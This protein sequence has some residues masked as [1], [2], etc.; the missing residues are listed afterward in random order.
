MLKIVAGQGDTIPRQVASIRYVIP[1][2]LPTEEHIIRI[3]LHRLQRI[4]FGQTLFRR[5]WLASFTITFKKKVLLL[6]RFI[7]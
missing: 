6:H 2:T 4:Q 3:I 7:S 1:D 5:V